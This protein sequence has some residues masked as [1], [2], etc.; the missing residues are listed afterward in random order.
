MKYLRFIL[1]LVTS[2]SVSIFASDA[3]QLLKNIQAKYSSINNFSAEVKNQ[4]NSELRGKIYY[5][6][7][8]KY[9]IE[10]KNSAIISDGAAYWNYNKKDNKVVIDSTSRGNNIFTIDYL[11]NEFPSRCTLSSSKEG[12]Y[13]TLILTPKQG[14]EID[15]NSAKLWISSD[16]LIERISIDAPNA[17]N[18]DYTFSDYKLNQNL[19]ASLFTF[20]VPKGCRIIDIR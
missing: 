17:D 3:D 1:L 5:S 6:R 18:L 7:G 2:F 16:N 13:S 14:S 12:K 4:G 8:N 19:S 20:E 10:F 9:R 11:L 15:F